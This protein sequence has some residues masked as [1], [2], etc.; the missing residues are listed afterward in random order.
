MNR[1]EIL[2]AAAQLF[3]QKGYAASSMQDIAQAVSLQKA[4]L[5][6]HVSSKQD[7][8]VELLDRALDMLIEHLQGVIDQP[9]PPD[10]KLQAAINSYVEAL[11]EHRELA[12]ILLLEHRSLEPALRERHVPRR[13]RFE[14][15]WRRLIQEGIDAGVFQSVHPAIVT[16]ALLGAMNW[17]IMWYH[18]DG[19]LS[20]GEIAGE[21]ALL[22]LRGLILCDGN[23]TSSTGRSTL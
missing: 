1:D 5:Y 16:R 17:T 14:S 15:L 6:H 12:S 10:E 22:F 18:Q 3:S 9:L 4:S 2:E 20:G 11:T 7:I 21:Y 19:P 23:Q 13:D 8:L